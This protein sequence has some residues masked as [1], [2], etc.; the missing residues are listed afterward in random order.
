MSKKPP[1]KLRIRTVTRR[2]WDSIPDS[3]DDKQRAASVL[4]VLYDLERQV[5]AFGWDQPPIFGLLYEKSRRELD[6]VT[7]ALEMEFQALP[8]FTEA[9]KRLN[10]Q[11]GQN[12]RMHW[13][14]CG[15]ADELRAYPALAPDNLVAV[16]L[17]HEAWIVLPKDDSPESLEELER[18]AGERKLHEHPNR[19]EIRGINA[20]DVAGVRY[21]VMRP[22]DPSIQ[23]RDLVGPWSDEANSVG[24]Q[25]PNA[26]QYFLDISHGR[27]TPDWPEYEALFD[28]EERGTRWKQRLRDEKDQRDAG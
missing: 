28:Y 18:V 22:R 1:R 27:P 4:E 2:R 24:G 26:L 15:V 19:Q 17:L 25:V 16:V 9:W 7:L 6:V 20:V 12:A 5:R 13:A 21:A 8:A 14:I 10:R 3:V 11:Y 23:T